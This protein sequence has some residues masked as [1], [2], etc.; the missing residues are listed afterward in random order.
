M[1][2]M[3]H[4]NTVVQN[5]I[6]LVIIQILLDVRKI[7]R[8]ADPRKKVR[9]IW[10]SMTLVPIQV[11]TITLP[12]VIPILDLILMIPPLKLRVCKLISLS[13]KKSKPEAEFQEI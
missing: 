10:L 11:P 4:P 12:I 13:Q 6:E 1:L 2:L 5:V 7:K 8:K 9:L 3:Y